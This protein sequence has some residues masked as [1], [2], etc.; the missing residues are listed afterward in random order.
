MRGADILLRP[1]VHDDL[2]QIKS[3]DVFGGDRK[4]EIAAGEVIVAVSGEAVVAY[5]S[6]HRKFFYR[7][8]I[9][10]LC[11]HGDHRRRGIA[12]QLWM[13]VEDIYRPSGELFSSTEADNQE[14]LLFFAKNGY[15][16]SGH[17]DNIQ[18][19][20]ELIFFKRL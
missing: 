19:E 16:P 10:Y 1:A 20:A 6:H 8:F 5:V 18:K 13:A 7:P 14:M 12:Q 2:A 15:K 17:I 3:F 4:G 9:G 11:V